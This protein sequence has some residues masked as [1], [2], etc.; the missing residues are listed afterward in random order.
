MRR[1]L[2][3]VAVFLAAFIL[4]ACSEDKTV[5]SN[6][7]GEGG[8][9][10]IAV[11]GRVMD[12][13][14]HEGAIVKVCMI[15]KNTMRQTGACFTDYTDKFGSFAIEGSAAPGFALASVRGYHH[16]EI[17][18]KK[19]LNEMEIACFSELSAETSRMYCSLF[20][21]SIRPRLEKLIKEDNVAY[22]D[23]VVQSESEFRTALQGVGIIHSDPQNA[24]HA[25]DLD[26]MSGDGPD[27]QWL[28]A[29]SASFVQTCLNEG[30]DE[31]SLSGCLQTLANSV[32]NG[33]VTGQLDAP[34]IVRLRE[35]VKAMDPELVTR[36][37][38]TYID[39]YGLVDAE[40]NAVQAASA[41]E[42]LDPDLD[43]L[44][45]PLDEDDDGDGVPDSDDC[46]SDSTGSWSDLAVGRYT[47]YGVHKGGQLANIGVEDL[48]SFGNDRGQMYGGTDA[49]WT[50][51]SAGDEGLLACA[52]K[53]DGTL[54]CWG[55][56]G[57]GYI[58]CSQ[59]EAA[60]PCQIN[61]DT[62]WS[63]VSAGG[64]Y[65]CAIKTDGALW[66]WG[67]SALDG[68]PIAPAPI[69]GSWNKASVGG[70]WAC[71]IATAGTLW[72]WFAGQET[73]PVQIG[74]DADWQHGDAGGYD[75]SNFFCDWPPPSG[76]RSNCGDFAPFAG[77]FCGVRSD[78]GG[79]YCF[80]ATSDAHI[81][82]PP[83][84]LAAGTRFTQASSSGVENDHRH[85]CA[86]TE[87]NNI[88][89]WYGA[90]DVEPKQV[91]TS[92]G[93]WSKLATSRS[94][95]CGL[96]NDGTVW[97]WDQATM[98]ESRIDPSADQATPF[99]P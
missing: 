6:D 35:A 5:T 19:S 13:P 56:T 40:G 90:L 57:I 25:N 59:N 23:A 24:L 4:G 16:L 33:F 91:A 55:Q 97:C 86:L 61:P 38:Q 89:C 62:D 79:L 66:C 45:N 9:Q 48:P 7:G 37:S 69:V 8:E 36:T 14:F 12:G 98:V 21:M 41:N 46:D 64:N 71:A 47:L 54:W 95:E 27:T 29:L 80:E 11:S 93:K 58:P 18:G 65:V 78:G 20:G 31:T 72:C 77:W 85:V 51:V 17:V 15:N 63:S 28:L 10:F 75:T 50:A 99:T 68:T 76:D 73:V 49:D 26:L 39:T 82:S 60:T 30:S 74:T 96:K 42:A 67:K 81:F 2:Q 84:Q 88:I 43:G 53:F 83:I 87:D 22:A 1:F 44:R 32:A 94:Y 3:F 92:C 52:I 34:L 70:D